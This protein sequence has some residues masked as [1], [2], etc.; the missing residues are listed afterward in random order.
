LATI[1]SIHLRHRAIGDQLTCMFIDQRFISKLDGITDPE[2]KRKLIGAEFIQV[3][4]EE[5]KRL[6]P[7]DLLPAALRLVG[8]DVHPARS[9]GNRCGLRQPLA[10]GQ[11]K[12]LLALSPCHTK[13]FHFQSRPSQIRGLNP[14]GS[15]S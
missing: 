4:E 5:S 9:S 6:G 7:F 2:E 3:F 11:P 10:R 8:S 14:D 13:D 15:T 1:L 12:G